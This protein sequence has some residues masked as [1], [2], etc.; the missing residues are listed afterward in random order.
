MVS[1]IGE[2]NREMAAKATHSTSENGVSSNFAAW[3]TVPGPLRPNA[4]GRDLGLE[5]VPKKGFIACEVQDQRG[6]DPN[7][8]QRS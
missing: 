7:Q 8:A 2:R 1:K 5:F 4:Q 6:I 3:G